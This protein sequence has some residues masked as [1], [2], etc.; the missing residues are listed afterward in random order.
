[1]TSTRYENVSESRLIAGFLRWLQARA[2]NL[3][4]MTYE[5]MEHYA[6]SYLKAGG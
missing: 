3:D 6:R 4:L 5:E 2:L 1:M